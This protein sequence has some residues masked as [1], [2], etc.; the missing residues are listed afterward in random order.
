MLVPF[1]IIWGVLGFLIGSFLNVVALRFN[2]GKSL[3]GRSGCY[4][5]GHQLRWYELFPVFSWLFQKGRCRSCK[6]KISPMYVF[7]ELTTGLLF[8]G[9]AFRGFFYDIANVLSFSYL[10][11]TIFLSLLFSILVIILLYDLRHKIIPDSLSLAFGFFSFL[12]IFFFDAGFV[13]ATALAIDWMHVLAGIIVPFPFVLIWLFSKGKL[14][15]LGDPKLMVGIG[16]LLGVSA[17]FSAVIFSFWAGAAY[18][19]IIMIVNKISSKRLLLGSNT[20]IMKA[21][22]PFAPFLILGTWLVVITTLNLFTL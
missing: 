1:T 11:G 22:V 15:G 5:C 13:L 14:I 20:R 9:I 10:V 16:L 7:G 17:G 21:E 3:E 2:T 18:A 19:V 4:S 8:A 6:S 12:S